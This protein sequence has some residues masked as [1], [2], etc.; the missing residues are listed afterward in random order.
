MREGFSEIMR[1]LLL[2]TNNQGKIREFH[3]LLAGISYE[4]VTPAG[5]GL[6]LEVAETGSSYA[7]NARLK[8]AAYARASGLLSLADDS[9]L[10]VDALGGEPGIRSSRYAGEN[11]TDKDRVDFLLSRLR[12]VPEAERK[13]CFRCVIAIAWP[14]GKVDLCTGRCDGI[15]I[16]GPRGSEGFGYDPIFY[17]P[18]FSK[19]MAELPAETKNRVSHRAR[20]A[21]KACE[22]LQTR[23]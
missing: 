22:L 10:E 4:L 19:T 2:A 15:I 20:A 21:Q 8:A 16:A 1:Q 6:K 17:F 5:L 14:D 7:E 23:I 9:G 18:E 11:A 3:S 13:A 12:H